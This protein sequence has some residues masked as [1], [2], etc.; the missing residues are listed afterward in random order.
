MSAPVRQEH[1]DAARELAKWPLSPILDQPLFD[2]TVDRIAQALADAAAEERER[3]AKIVQA[4]MLEVPD[5]IGQ[6]WNDDLQRIAAAIRAE[7][8]K[9]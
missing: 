7:R 5:T 4:E 2:S 6:A 8:E 1:R 3:C 9:L